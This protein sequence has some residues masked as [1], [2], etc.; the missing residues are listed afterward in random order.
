M[1]DSNMFD[2]NMMKTARFA[3]SWIFATI[4]LAILH[5]NA[6]PLPVSSFSRD[7]HGV[8]L[9]M[10]P[11]VLRLEVF[12]PRVIRVTYVPGEKLPANRSLC[13]IEKPGR[14]P[15]KV[16]ETKDDVALSTDELEARVNRA[17]G[18]VS[19]YDKNGKS[20]LMEKPGGK[21]LAPDEVG[22]INTLRSTDEFVLAPDEAIYGLGQHQQGVM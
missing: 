13:V 21:S 10:N 2:S 14:A 20:V 22:G 1:F 15:W 4:V 19:F 9:K 6:A 8:T 11:G 17:T 16:L 3:L 7:A 18:A 5:A 12:S